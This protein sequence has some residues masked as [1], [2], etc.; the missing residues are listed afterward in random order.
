MLEYD[1]NRLYPNIFCF[2][3][4]RHGGKSTGNY[5]SFN[6]TSYCGD[7]LN[8]VKQNC[9]L[10]ASLLPVQPNQLIIPHQTHETH[11]RTIDKSFTQS[12]EKEQRALLEGIDALITNIPQQCLCISTADCIPVLC[13]DTR[14]HAIAAI[15]AGWRGTVKRIVE[16]TLEEMQRMY[17]TEGKDIVACIGPGISVDSF[18]VGDEVYQAFQDAHFPMHRIAKHFQKWHLDL[19]EANRMQLLNAGVKSLQIESAQLC[20]F[21][22]NEDF[23]SARRQGIASG[24]ILSGI[25]LR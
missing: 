10:L 20:T 8:K 18:E 19:W 15:H 2:S 16:K 22:H 3:T 9:E 1:I 21:T 5:T 24:R 11:I 23:F 6:C 25:I 17:G 12:G 7:N 4:T 14:N 13:Y